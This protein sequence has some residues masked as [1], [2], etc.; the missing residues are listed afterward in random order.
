M[1]PGF[2]YRGLHWLDVTNQDI[3]QKCFCW[4]GNSYPIGSKF[5]RLGSNP[6][7]SICIG[8]N[9]VYMGMLNGFVLFS[10]DA[11]KIENSQLSLFEKKTALI[12]IMQLDEHNLM[13]PTSVGTFYDIVP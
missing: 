2:F 13:L 8:W 5:E 9:L 10:H 3:Q 7:Q 1:K 12:A 11:P 4:D 6:R